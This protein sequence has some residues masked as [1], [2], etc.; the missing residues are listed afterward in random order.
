MNSTQRFKLTKHA[1]VQR[2]DHTTAGTATGLGL[3]AGVG[4]VNGLGFVDQAWKGF[5]PA[6]T[7]TEVLSKL[8]D[9]GDIGNAA[10]RGNFK[11]ILKSQMLAKLI[12]GAKTG[13][14]AFGLSKAI[15]NGVEPSML[16]RLS[17]FVNRGG[18]MN[19]RLRG[20]G[21]GAL[22]GGA[23]LG[24]IGHLLGSAASDKKRWYHAN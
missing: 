2:N 18:L 5:N 13:P 12:E 15:T 3:G 9:P 4:A 17:G 20:A 24:G 22:A 6:M 21:L 11:N 1:F 23:A 8:L 19:S 7:D 14:G 16:T 10:M